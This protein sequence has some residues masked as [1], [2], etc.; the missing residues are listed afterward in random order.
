MNFHT[1]D[2]A[3][4]VNRDHRLQ[5]VRSCIV[6]VVTRENYDNRLPSRRLRMEKIIVAILPHIVQKILFHTISF[7]T[8]QSRGP[9]LFSLCKYTTT[10]S[11]CQEFWKIFFFLIINRIQN[12]LNN[13]R[14]KLLIIYLCFRKNIKIYPQIQI[15]QSLNSCI[16]ATQQ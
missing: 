11:V 10:T 12:R 6:I 14:C 5:K 16:F 15:Q 1:A 3:H 8:A 9:V 13:S 2:P 7:Y 4:V